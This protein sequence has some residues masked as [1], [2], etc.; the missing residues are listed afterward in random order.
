MVVGKNNANQQ[1]ESVY[2]LIPRADV[3]AAKPPRYCPL[4]VLLSV[5]GIVFYR[6]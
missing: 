2:N 6:T 1:E 4:R 5:A 3:R